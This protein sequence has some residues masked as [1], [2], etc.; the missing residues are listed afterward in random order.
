M[1]E[2]AA[3]DAGVLEAYGLGLDEPIR[4]SA[5]HGEGLNDLYSRLAPLAEEFAERAAADAPETDV[6]I[7]E[8]G[9]EGERVITTA[10]PLQRKRRSREVCRSS[11]GAAKRTWNLVVPP[12]SWRVTSPARAASSS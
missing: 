3:A 6:E 1:L 4:L 12:C 11:S 7:G 10:K 8:D 9:D 5:E 2:G